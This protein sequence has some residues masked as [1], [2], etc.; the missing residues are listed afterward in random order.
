MRHWN[1]NV[2]AGVPVQVPGSA[3]R[4]SPTG[5]WAEMV[6]GEV[7]LGAPA[8]RA[9]PIPAVSANSSTDSAATAG[10]PSQRKRFMSG[11]P[12]VVGLVSPC[13]CRFPQTP[14]SSLRD[15]L[16]WSDEGFARRT[17]RRP[18]QLRVNPNSTQTRSVDLA[19]APAGACCGPR[20]LDRRLVRPAGADDPRRRLVRDD[21]RAP[22]RAARDLDRARA[23]TAAARPRDARPEREPALP[24]PRRAGLRRPSCPSLPARRASAE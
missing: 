20:T 16:W 4:S 23:I 14:N 8:V 3:F 5:A 6:G 9:E 13:L 24:A 15:V 7:L 21:G 11:P 12:W 19:H 10:R 17:R 22:L 18:H 1:V 2:G